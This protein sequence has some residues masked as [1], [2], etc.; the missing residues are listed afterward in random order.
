MKYFLVFIL[1]FVLEIFYLRLA[2]KKNISDVPNH[3]SAHSKVTLRGGGIIVLL[4]VLVFNILF[5]TNES[6]ILFTISTFLVATIS[7]VDD[8]LI[9]SSRV[10]VSIHIIAFTLIFYNFGLFSSLD[11]LVLVSLFIFYF[12]SLG[13]LNIYN[14]MDGINGITFLN[15][16]ISYSTILYINFYMKE[17]T[18][19]DLLIVL[20]LSILVFGFFNFRRKA[21]CFAGDI[22]S[23]TIGFSLIYFSINYYLETSNILIFLIFTVYA[24]EGGFTILERVLRKENIFEA[25]KRHLYQIL[26]ND[27]KINHLKISL[28]YFI[29]QA[30]I[31]IITVYGMSISFNPTILFIITF[32]CCSCIYITIKY[33]VLKHLKELL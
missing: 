22:G 28:S 33:I 21:I 11:L 26:A 10:R 29:V 2:K 31:S 13:M 3:R 5:S 18:S 24:V 14:F 20:I 19:T 16:L 6:I 1:L 32:F 8:I 25:H 9:L 15:A 4:S 30:L 17:F 23:I 12:L 27:L 7:F